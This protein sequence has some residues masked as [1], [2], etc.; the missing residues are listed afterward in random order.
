MTH[1]FALLLILLALPAWASTD[2]PNEP[3]GLTTLF[4]CPFNSGDDCGIRND[5][6]TK[7][8]AT[9]GGN[10]LSP[11]SA[12]DTYLAAGATTG[13][14]QWGLDL[15]YPTELYVGTWW[16]TNSDFQGM[17][18]NT[19]K[20]LF[21]RS[22]AMDNN[23]LVWQG[24]PGSPRTIK[25]YMQATYDNCG[26]PGEYG[27]CYTKGD[28]TGWFEPNVGNGTV[29]AGSGWHRLE[30][31]I[32]TST[33][34]TSRDG[35]IRWWVDGRPVG[36]YPNVNVSP[37][38]LHDFQINHTWDGTNCLLPPYRDLAKSWHH[39]WDHLHISANKG[40]SGPVIPQPPAN[41]GDVLDVNLT[42]K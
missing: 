28:G 11:P 34:K 14:G 15:D 37:G 32:K 24:P 16:S 9:P 30:F 25:W 3:A 39:Y 12:F 19:N 18:N 27:M 10:P 7:A 29:V 6:N 38:G 40:S 2:W 22:P 5:Y 20:M 33:S 8:F 13:N 41:P 42:V 17:C 1:L 21:A 31:Y 26:H 36:D 35:I 23:F 4:D